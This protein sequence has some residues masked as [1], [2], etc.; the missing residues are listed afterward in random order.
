MPGSSDRAV[1]ERAELDRRLVVTFDKD[2]G[3]LAFR[4]RL[5]AASG[6]VLF[7]IV[8][9]SARSLAQ[10]VVAA[11]TSRTDWAGYFSVVEEDSV[12]MTALPER[13]L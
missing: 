3:E 9:S 8:D 5:P 6:I 12:R 13:E 4:Y 10:R 2:F 11:L 7:R 1:L